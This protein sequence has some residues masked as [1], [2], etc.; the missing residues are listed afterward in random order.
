MLIVDASVAVKWFANESD[1]EAALALFDSREVLAAPELIF[2]EVANTLWQ[3]CRRGHM[4]VADAVLSMRRLARGLV[5]QYPMAPLADHAF[6]LA[7]ELD[8]S[9]YDCFYFALAEREGATLVTADK[10]F[11]RRLRQ[12][13]RGASIALLGE[14]LP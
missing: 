7:R 9:A 5:R 4:P 1:S 11:R 13:R 14:P 2:V 3:K 6:A 8:H 10:Q 12:A